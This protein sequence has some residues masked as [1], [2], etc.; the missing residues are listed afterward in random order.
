MLI[1]LSLEAKTE[2]QW[3]KENMMASYDATDSDNGS[4]HSV[5]FSYRFLCNRLGLRVQN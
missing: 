3:C 4:P 1:N 5:L 2:T